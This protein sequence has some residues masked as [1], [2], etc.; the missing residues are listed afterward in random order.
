[1]GRL[2]SLALIALVCSLAACTTATARAKAPIEPAPTRATTAPVAT[3]STTTTQPFVHQA[4]DFHRR[5]DQP[6]PMRVMVVGDSVGITLANGL[7]AWANETG[8]A[9]VRDDARAWCSLGRYLPRD[10]FGPQNA[11]AGCDDWATRWGDD[12]GTFDPDV[13]FVMFTVWEVIPRKLPGTPDFAR[14]GDPA[15]DAWQ[16]S[17]YQHAADVLGARGARVVFFSIACES[18]TRITRGEPYWYVNRRTLP[19]LAKSRPAVRLIDLDQ[20]LCGGSQ[21]R[22]DLGGVSDLRP[23]HAHYSDAGALA[24]ARWLMPIVLGRSRPPRYALR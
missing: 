8:K 12:I 6:R 10:A 17:E 9:M 3:T 16:L 24:L 22:N 5:L 4:T 21:L 18:N 11:S 13:V 7:Q 23:D 14:P 2:R 20:L 15:L 19:R 1:M